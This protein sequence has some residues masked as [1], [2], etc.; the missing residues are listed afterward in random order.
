MVNL[1]VKN[2]VKEADARIKNKLEIPAEKLAANKIPTYQCECLLINHVFMCMSVADASLS[3]T[4][5][6]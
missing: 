3:N 6:W 4:K 2:G 5:D 1:A